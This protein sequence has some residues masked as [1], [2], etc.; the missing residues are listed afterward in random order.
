MQKVYP[1]LVFLSLATILSVSQVQSQSWEVYD[2]QGN[3][4][5]RA[6]YQKLQVLSETVLVGKNESGL[7]LL[8][9]DLKPMVNL[10]GEE[11]YRYLE[12][13]IW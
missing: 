1:F 12:P 6:L 11:V 10:Q 7:F 9:R 4:K 5:S 2:L 8:S 13:W 3:L